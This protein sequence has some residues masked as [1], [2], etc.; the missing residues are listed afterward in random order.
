MVDSWLQPHDRTT[1]EPG[2]FTVLAGA[3]VTHVVRDQAVT[4][5]CVVIGLFSH[6]EE[7]SPS[8]LRRF[9]HHEAM[10]LLWPYLRAA[11]GEIG[12]MMDL[13][14]PPLPTLDVLKVL[15]ATEQ[16][17]EDGS[18]PTPLPTASPTKSRR[19]PKS[20]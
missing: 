13:G 10:V 6:G 11:V 3:D 19:R 12:H 7:V 17:D 18:P 9:Q 15:Q 5:H 20:T 16:A 14:L 8:L 4:V 2:V 1:P